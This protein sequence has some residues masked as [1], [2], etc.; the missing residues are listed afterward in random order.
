M[1]FALT[2]R[3]HVSPRTLH[4]GAFLSSIL[5]PAVKKLGSPQRSPSPSSAPVAAVRPEVRGPFLFLGDEKLVI[6]AVTYGTFAPD[7]EGHRFPPR[8]TVAFDFQEM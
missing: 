8:E 3:F 5:E 7:S 4:T 2:S 1:D 6:K